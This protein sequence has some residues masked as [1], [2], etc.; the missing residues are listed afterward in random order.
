MGS[1]RFLSI[2]LICLGLLAMLLSIVA[3]CLGPLFPMGRCDFCVESPILIMIGVVNTILS[4]FPASIGFI[5]VYADKRTNLFGILSIVFY[6][7]TLPNMG[8]LG[9]VSIIY[10][11]TMEGDIARAYMY[12]LIIIYLAEVMISAI[13]LY[14]IK[15]TCCSNNDKEIVE[16]EQ[17][18]K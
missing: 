11:G 12:I 3:A 6:I 4:I 9:W 10:E 13:C 15:F 18:N 16:M 5:G 1:I 8:A 2:S 14:K 7:L 17:M